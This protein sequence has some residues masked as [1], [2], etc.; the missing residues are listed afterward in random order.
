[1]LSSYTIL[2]NELSNVINAIN[3]LNSTDVIGVILYG[4]K[5]FDNVTNFKIITATIKF[6]KTRKRFEE[7]LF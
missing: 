6:I 2:M 1:M 4:D 3:S 5:H 7:A